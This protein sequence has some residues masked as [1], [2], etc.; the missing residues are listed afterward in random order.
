MRKYKLGIYEKALPKNISWQDRLSIAKSCGFDFVE[1]S[2]DET[3][4]RLARLEWSKEQR[5]ALVNSIVTTGITIPSMCLSGHRR[6]PFGAR[7]QATREKAYEIMAKAIQ[8]AVDTGIRT[9][10]LA[11]YDVYYEEQDQGTIER[12]QQGLAWAVELAAS[13]QVTL[14]VEI[15]DTPFMSSISR[16][17]KWD[18]M[19]NSPWF[20]VYPDIGNLSAWNDNI[21]QE[22]ALGINKISAIHLKDTYKVTKDCAGQ[23]RDVPFGD[24]CVDFKGFFEILAKLNYRGA[25]LIE[26]W[27]EKAEEPIAEIINARRWIEQKM[28]EGGF[29]C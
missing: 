9:I 18:E 6:F 26:M 20:T 8:F 11:G 27:T 21:E 19:I 22:L 7:D 16:W 29:E 15:M 13:N 24:G 5:L 4:E 17:K 23:F 2:I 14:A 12:F 25:F 1:M 10:Q 3:D 28:K